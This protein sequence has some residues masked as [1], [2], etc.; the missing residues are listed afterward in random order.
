MIAITS[1]EGHR[2]FYFICLAPINPLHPSWISFSGFSPPKMPSITTSF[3][4]HIPPRLYIHSPPLYASIFY[5]LPHTEP[6]YPPSRTFQDRHSPVPGSPVT[7]AFVLSIFY[8]S[9]YHILFLVCSFF[10]SLCQWWWSAYIGPHIF[11]SHHNPCI[12]T[13]SVFRV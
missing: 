10:L 8:S 5:V 7:T 1:G 11:W 13:S 9:P 6:N 12:F 2:Q 3:V 4:V